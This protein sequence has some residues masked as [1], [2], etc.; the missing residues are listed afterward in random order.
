MKC[1]G[2]MLVYSRITG[3][4]QPIQ[5]WNDGKVEE[6]KDRKKMEIVTII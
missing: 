3:Y 6:F 1:K 5:Q 2:K 4:F